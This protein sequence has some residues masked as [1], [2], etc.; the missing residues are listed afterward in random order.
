MAIDTSNFDLYVTAMSGGR[1]V[2][3]TRSTGLVYT[4]AGTGSTG[5]SSGDGGQATAAVVPGP[6]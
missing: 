5:A 6:A 1:V 4:F 2:A 3:L